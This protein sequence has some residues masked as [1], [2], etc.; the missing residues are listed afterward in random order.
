MRRPVLTRA[1]LAAVFTTC[2][3]GFAWLPGAA[4]PQNPPPQPPPT[5]QPPVGG[6]AAA[7]G[8][9]R[10]GRGGS[11]GAAVYAQFCASC[12]GP[13]LQGGIGRQP[14]RR[15]VEVRQRRRQHHRE[16]SRRTAGH[17]DGA[18]QGPG[19]RGADPSARLL[20]PHAGGLLKGKPEAKVDP[21]G[22]VV[23]SEKQTVKLEVVAKDLETPWGIALPARRPDARHR[24]SGHG[25]ASSRRARCCRR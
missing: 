22:H 8:Q 2:A 1:A 3:A 6:S 18:V 23:K 24:A 21:E 7:P 19:Q 11:P 25:S 16:H 17:G 13:T 9:G 4:A 10:G 14:R 15:R 20:H 5:A 12:H